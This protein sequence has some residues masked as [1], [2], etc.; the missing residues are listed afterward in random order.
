[1]RCSFNSCFSAFPCSLSLD[2]LADA[3]YA[4]G[5]PFHPAYGGQFTPEEQSTALTVM[6]YL[7]N[8]IRSG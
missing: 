3:Q 8:F 5:L 4:F 2:L 6:Q 1:M 7:S